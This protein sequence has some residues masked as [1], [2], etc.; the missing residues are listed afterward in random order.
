M[1]EKDAMRFALL[2]PVQVHGD[3]APV[4]IRGV[5]R[6]TLLAALL[7][8]RGSVVSADRLAELIWGERPPA[9]VTTSLYNQVM[10]LRQALG[11]DAERIRAVAPGYLIHVEPGELDLDE[12]AGLCA[13]ARRAAA[14]AD[15]PGAAE[16]YSAALALWRGEMLA[17]VPALHEQAAIHQYEED[18]LLAL[19]GRIEADLNLGRQDE[20][21]GELRTLI[22][23][24]PL[25]EAFHGQLMLALYRSG[26]QADAL[27]VYRDLRRALIREL[28]VEPAAAVQ[29]LH[30]R[31]LRS[32]PELR[33]PTPAA[34]SGSAPPAAARAAPAMR[35]APRQLPAD[36]RLFT[37]RSAELGDLVALA[38]AAGEGTDT[39]M[40]VISAIN[41]LGGIGKTALA[42]HAGHQAGARFPDGQLFI[43]LRG[44][45]TDP[46]PVRPAQALDY[47]LRSLGVPPQS[48]PDEL[49][50]R[51]ALYRSALAGTRTLIVLDNA[52]DTAQVRPLLPGGPGCL[53]LI[54]SRNRLMGLDDAHFVSLGTL[55]TAEAVA[56]LRGAAGVDQDAEDEPGLA[57]LAELCGRMPLALRIVAAR[58]RH[59]SHLTVQDLVAELREE[60]GRLDG[61]RDDDRDLTSVFESSYR[62]LPAAERDLFR[63]LGTV[64]GTDFDAYAAAHLADRGLED[65]QLLL[66]A[67]HDRSLL[68][69]RAPGRFQFHDLL[70][71]YAHELTDAWAESGLRRDRLFDYYEAA[72]RLADGCVT[73]TTRPGAVRDDRP[74]HPMPTLDDRAAGISWLRAETD[75]LLAAADD[76]HADGAR[77][78]HLADALATTLN[79]DHRIRQALPLHERALAAAR[80]LGDG[81]AEANALSDLGL[82]HTEVSENSTAYA[83]LEQ[84]LQQ[85]LELGSRLGEANT[86]RALGHIDHRI[87][88][89]TQAAELA[90]RALAIYE[91]VGDHAGE[92]E[93]LSEIARGLHMNG[94]YA[95][96]ARLRER[97][98]KLSRDIGDLL[99]EVNLLGDLA[100][101]HMMTGVYADAAAYLQDAIRAFRVVDSRQGEASAVWELARVRVAQG[102]YREAIDLCEQMLPV[103]QSSGFRQGEAYLLWTMGRAW[104][105]LGETARADEV[106]SQGWRPSSAPATT[107]AAPTSCATWPASARPRATTQPPRP[108]PP[109]P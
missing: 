103:Q 96:A 78:I 107:S 19:Q 57:E 94:R 7:L 45:G 95:E 81:L 65:A 97:A 14:G 37:G 31:I 3:D 54:T 89:I 85:Y 98:L 2:G 25:R 74:R 4:E 87:G 9:G 55:S 86:Y 69:Q 17:D 30:H 59:Q 11:E 99:G 52:A 82:A 51:A 13:A 50:E 104:L 106:L 102:R 80:A 53:V 61:L 109:R 105:G 91:E 26:R 42:V 70:R 77:V 79:H 108:T 18:R 24:H 47:L 10:R 36:T 44:Y 20:L 64:P 15:W 29:E 72:G 22:G 35:P 73:R 92:A 1:W 93:S 100:R 43:D 46:A 6:R 66:D 41:G 90:E 58:L 32:D 39:G 60:S 75:N 101:A 12:F 67:L 63:A 38:R 28:G 16:H 83:R 56:L 49:D 40:I 84:A 5:L 8:S 23:Y 88:K 48:I 34:E 71:V 68:I 33:A 62:A 76:E 21:V 27:G